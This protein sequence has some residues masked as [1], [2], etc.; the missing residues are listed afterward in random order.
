[1]DSDDKLG[2]SS[3]YQLKGD[4]NSWESDRECLPNLQHYHIQ[5][6][7]MSAMFYVVLEFP[8]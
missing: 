4:T 7:D 6:L 8:N 1:M 5:L 2:S 3:R